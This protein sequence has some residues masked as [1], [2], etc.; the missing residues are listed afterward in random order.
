SSKQS[1][2]GV[3]SQYNI[4]KK[5]TSRLRRFSIGSVHVLGLNPAP[6]ICRTYTTNSEYKMQNAHEEVKKL[7]RTS[8]KVTLVIDTSPGS[9]STGST[10]SPTQN[11]FLR[12]TRRVIAVVVHE[13]QDEQIGA[14]F[15]FKW[16][17]SE[18]PSLVLV[19]TL[20][21]GPDFEINLAQV[22]SSALGVPAQPDATTTT[23]RPDVHSEGEELSFMCP[24][25][26]AV[27]LREECSRFKVPQEQ[28]PPKA[29]HSWMAAYSPTTVDRRTFAGEPGDEDADAVLIRDDWVLKQVRARK[30]EYASTHSV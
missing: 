13:A 26:E 16:T 14:L 21:I 10:T 4:H 6:N 12:P 23:K 27:A 9:A 1:Y 2:Q 3:L 30:D 5:T 25:A 20:A 7:L 22:S 18:P 8:E 28:D 29:T 19:A 11:N 17:K 15:I 24:E